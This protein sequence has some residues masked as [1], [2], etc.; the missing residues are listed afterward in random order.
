MKGMAVNTLTDYEYKVRQ[1][2]DYI[3]KN[4]IR[5]FRWSILQK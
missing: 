2:M 3:R 5:I 4:L 1:A